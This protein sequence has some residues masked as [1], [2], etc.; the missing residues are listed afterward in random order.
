MADITVS[1]RMKV[2]TLR[3]QFKEAFGATLRVYKGAKFADD[4]VTL[5]SIRQ[6]DAKKSGEMVI[7]GNMLVGN[8]EIKFEETYGIKI[9]VASPDNSKLSDNSITLSAAGKEK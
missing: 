2:G 9:Q 3:T 7:K 4:E 5:A 8:F 1:G 6:E